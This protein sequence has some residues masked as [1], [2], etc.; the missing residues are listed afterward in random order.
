MVYLRLTDIEARTLAHLL[1]MAGDTY[2][3]R[4]CNDFD[5]RAELKLS[6]EAAQKAAQELRASMQETQCCD[7]EEGASTSPYFLDWL[8]M[9]H[10]QKR[11]LA[12]LPSEQKS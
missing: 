1:E 3:N 10:F 6:P 5:L 11:V 8:L 2:G 7:A 9:Q 4:G 12:L